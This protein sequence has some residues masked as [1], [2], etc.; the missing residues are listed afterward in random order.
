MSGSLAEFCTPRDRL[1][2]T[3]PVCIGATIHVELAATGLE[4][5]GPD[6]GVVTAGET[7]VNQR[8][9]AVLVAEIKILMVDRPKEV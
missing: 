4:R 2:F 8:G 7:V 6:R 3:G 9:Q 1:R 5:K